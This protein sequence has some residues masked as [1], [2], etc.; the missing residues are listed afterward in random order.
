M[1]KQRKG[2]RP[3]TGR[4]TMTI[5]L[6]PEEKLALEDAAEA[7]GLDKSAYVRKALTNQLKKDGRVKRHTTES[8]R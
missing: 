8:T 5:R 1:P 2:G 4:I 3:E 7:A 6:L